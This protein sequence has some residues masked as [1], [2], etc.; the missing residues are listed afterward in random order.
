MAKATNKDLINKGLSSLLGGIKND[1][2]NTTGTNLKPEVVAQVN[3]IARIPME[4]ISANPNQPRKDFD[5]EALDELANSLKMHD[6]IQPITVHKIGANKYQIVSGERRWRAAKQAGLKDIPAYIRQVNDSQLLELALLENL[7]R[8]DLNAIEVALSYKRMMDELDYT[9]EKVG[10]RMGKERSTITNYVRLLKLPPSIQL[11]V[12]NN[13]I[14]MGHAKCLINIEAVEKQLFVYKEIK[15]SHL[16]V[17]QTEELV[18]KMSVAGQITKNVEKPKLAPAYQKI[19]DKISSQFG[20]KV[21]VKHTKKGN[22]SITFEYN[23]MQELN[24]LL[25]GLQVT[26]S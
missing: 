18:R 24:K 5:K 14:S 25:E 2:K 19:Q 12:R 6:V 11:A 13:D 8:E 10:E 3:N 4:Q 26:V 20:T 15:N 7:Q 17:R 22:G 1:L 23:S 21:L 16:N 9:Q